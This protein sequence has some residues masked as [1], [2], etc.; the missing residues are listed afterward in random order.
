MTV[1]EKQGGNNCEG[2]GSSLSNGTSLTFHHIFGGAVSAVSL[3]VGTFVDSI[4][5]VFAFSWNASASVVHH[6]SCW[7]SFVVAVK[8]GAWIG[9]DTLTSGGGW[10]LAGWAGG[11]VSE[12]ALACALGLV[13]W[14]WSG[15][16]RVVTGELGALGLSVGDGGGESEKGEELFH[17]GFSGGFV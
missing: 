3:G 6:P 17:C 1:S 15:G 12:L 9:G 10:L 13:S 16:E 14:D 4:A 11:A 2:E 7:V 8:S 5:W